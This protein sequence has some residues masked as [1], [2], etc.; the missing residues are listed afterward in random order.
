MELAQLSDLVDQFTTKR[1]E[2][3][4][5]DKSAKLLKA[6]ETV[7]KELILNQ[8]IVNEVGSVGGKTHT[9]KRQIKRKPQVADWQAFNTYVIE[10]NALEL[11]QRRIHEKAV[12]ERTEEGPIPGIEFFELNDLS[13]S[14]L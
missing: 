5:Q 11:F 3:L 7:L 2:R 13:V 10:N 9:V 6:E 8:L 4:A 1:A 12:N 14:K